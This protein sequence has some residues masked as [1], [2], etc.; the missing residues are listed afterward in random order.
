[1]KE[2]IKKRTLEAISA[3]PEGYQSD[4][5]IKETIRCVL[6]EILKEQGLI[7]IPAFRN[8]RYPEGPVDMAAMSDSKQIEM[9]FCGNALV[10]LED[11]KITVC[12]VPRVERRLRPLV[13]RP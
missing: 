7:P 10:E 12:K 2:V 11:V 6:F 13:Q 3:I 9:V 8:P 4:L 1:M 5:V